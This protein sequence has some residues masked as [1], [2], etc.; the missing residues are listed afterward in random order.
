MALSYRLQFA[1]QVVSTVF[2]VIALYFVSKLIGTNPELQQ[3]GG[4]FP[5]AAI[6]LAVMSYFQTGFSSFANAI[7]NEQFMGTLESLLMTPIKIHR[8]VL[9]ASVWDFFWAT[10]TSVIYILAASLFFGI[11]LKGNPVLALFLLV[12]T[13]SIFAGLGVISASFIMV[14]KRGDPLGF[15]LGAVSTLIGGFYPR[16]A[17]PDY[18]Q[19]ASYALPITYGLDGLREVLLKGQPLRVILPKIVVLAAFAIVVLPLSLF[20]F[21]KA[22]RKAQRD[23]TL[24]HY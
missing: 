24:L 10:L 4:Y 7:R 21:K 9:A 15:L 17:L 11:E 8:V 6:G 16:S 3:Y 20:C 19:T 22:V 14:F 1:L 12:L 18:L 13:T 23:G 5:F 2:V